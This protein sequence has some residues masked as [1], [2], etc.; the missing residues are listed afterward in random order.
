VLAK[1]YSGAV[2]GVDAYKVE[3]EVHAGQ[4]DP[5]IIVV[6]LP[7]T[8]VK[9]SKDR[10]NTAIINSGFFPHL[11]RTTVNLAPANIKKEGPIYDLPIALGILEAPVKRPRAA[12]GC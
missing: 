7:D 10:V 11:G 4:G 8:A 9:E 1:V 2:F 5:I 12:G 3:I 6:G